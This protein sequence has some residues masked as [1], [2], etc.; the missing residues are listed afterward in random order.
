MCYVC[1]TLVK[2]HDYWTV[3]RWPEGTV[4]FCSCI[5]E[6]ILPS[7]SYTADRLAQEQIT[8]MHSEIPQHR[9]LYAL[10]AQINPPACVC[11]HSLISNGFLRYPNNK[12]L[13][14]DRCTKNLKYVKKWLFWTLILSKITYFKGRVHKGA[15]ELKTVFTLALYVEMTYSE[16]QTP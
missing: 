9:R 12:T 1:F 2:Q 5:F 16:P 6:V 10:H 11:F 3:D 4:L 7:S 8:M 14:C 15:I 13:L